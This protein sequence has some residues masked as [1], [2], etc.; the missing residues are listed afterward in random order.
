M[1]SK[2][3]LAVVSAVG[4]IATGGVVGYR[5]FF[6]NKESLLSKIREKLKNA[7][8]KKI[9]VSERDKIWNSWKE[10]YGAEKTPPILGISKDELP[11]WCEE[12]LSGNDESK[13]E[14]V[15]KWCVVNTRSAREELKA[16][17]MGLL[18]E[19]SGTKWEDAWDSYNTGKGEQGIVDST[20]VSKNITEK[21]KGGPA[22]KEWCETYLSKKMYEF[23]E[24][25]KSYEKVA[26][27]CVKKPQSTTV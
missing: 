21:A 4:A 20:F 19:D 10:F 3:A 27:W 15:S 25:G 14:L 9:L 2:S 1:V 22:L 18:D 17:S 24:G 5:Y 11:K 13:M 7:L 12:S 26:K 6:K 8:H 16:G 23:F